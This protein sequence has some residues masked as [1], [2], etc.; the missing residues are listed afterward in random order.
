MLGASTLGVLIGGAILFFISI[1]LMMGIAAS[2]TSKPAFRLEDKTVL[3]LTLDKPVNDRIGNS[4]FDY[5]MMGST[6]SYSLN[7]ILSAI[8]KAKE[9]DKIKGIYIKTG[10]GQIG[11]ASIE[12]IRAALEDFKSSGKFVITYGDNIA[13][14]L[15]YVASA[16][17]KIYLNPQGMLDF[18]GL[19][20]NT[21]FNRDVFKKWGVDIQVFKVGTY[22]SAVEPMIDTKMS[23]ANREQVTSYLTDIW[24]HMLDGISS[25]RNI[26]IEDLNKYAD[27]Y[28]AFTDPQKVLEYGLV[29]GLKYESEVEEHIKGLMD[30]NKEQK[31]KFA[32]VDNINSIPD[33][34]AM[35]Q[36]DRIAILY[37]EGSIESAG[38]GPSL[39][40]IRITDKE[41]VKELRRLKDDDNVKAVVFRV[42]SGGGSAYASEQIWHAVK[43]LKAVKPIVV[44]MGDYA[45]S[46]GYYISCCATKIVAE[47][48]TLTG[49]IGIFGLYPSAEQLAQKMGAHYD[50]VATNQNSGLG[51]EVLSIPFIGLG[52]LP[53]RPLNN[54]EMN[55]LQAYVERG[56]DLFISRCA[57]GR[58]MTKDQIDAIGQGRVWTGSQALGIGLVDE[59]GSMSRA[60]EIAANEAG[61]DN[62]SMEYYP[63][64]KDFFAQLMEDSSEGIAT[65]FTKAIMG[66]EAYEQKMMIN[67]WQNF[68]YRQAIMIE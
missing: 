48:N 67:A 64:E 52:L 58:G 24:G 14:N 35:K 45:A 36:K 12:P 21:Q 61:I 60:I 5:L 66:N 34:S 44:S 57:E 11:Y 59:L 39:G 63:K 8:K 49:S 4:P 37:A 16:S 27:E 43:E 29:D 20:W 22:K 68:D 30:L 47:H 42:N 3:A 51:N 19:S 28:L 6:K 62:Y 1:I 54:A 32:S 31:I 10:A 65:R 50:G 56:Y 40:G 25:N 26:S 15:Y 53:A 18:R 13:Q 41:Y 55:M 46:G 38:D 33:K 2:F 9:N 17:D 23:D 7:S